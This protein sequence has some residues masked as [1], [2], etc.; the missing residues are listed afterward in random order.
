MGMTQK[1]LAARIEVKPS[2][3]GAYEENRAEPRLQTLL[4]LAELFKIS[5]NDLLLKDFNTSK[6]HFTDQKKAELRVLSISVDEK[7]R[8]NIELVPVK[9]QAGYLS[10]YG[11][12]E[13]IAELPRFRLP[14][15]ETGTYR[16]FEIRGDSMLPLTPGSFV[17]GEYVEDFADIRDGRSYVL[18]TRNDGI[19]Y[20]RVYLKNDE[21]LIL[22][23]DNPAYSAYEIKREELLELWQSKLFISHDV[24]ENLFSLQNLGKI[25]MELQQEIIKL[26]TK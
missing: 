6:I 8:E 2:S 14:F 13:F 15:L 11:D 17:I 19:I 9:A 22:S 21:L 24:Q 1:D 12:P 16:A 18:I 4:K 25:V 7:N 20:K 26:K 23:S 10:G 3:I 5:L